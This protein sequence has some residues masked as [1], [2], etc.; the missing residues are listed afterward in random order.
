MKT[1]LLQSVCIN[2]GDREAYISVLQY[3]KN[4]LTQRYI[5]PDRMFDMDSLDYTF[6]GF[7]M[8]STKQLYMTKDAITP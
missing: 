5:L 1:I 7:Y 3:L 4:T 2:G 8:P 6:D